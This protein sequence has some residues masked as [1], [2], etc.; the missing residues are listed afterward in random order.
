MKVEVKKKIEI[1]L[2]Q[3]LRF[4]SGICSNQTESYRMSNKCDNNDDTC[5]TISHIFLS[6]PRDFIERERDRDRKRDYRQ[7][8]T[9]QY[10][11]D[12]IFSGVLKKFPPFVFINNAYNCELY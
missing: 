5:Y 10:D 7:Q 8:R 12:G 11:L 6:M 9:T 1:I 4:I 2:G 3:I